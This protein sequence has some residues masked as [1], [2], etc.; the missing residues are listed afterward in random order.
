MGERA[1]WWNP[2]ARGVIFGLSRS[3]NRGHII[4]AVVEGVFFNLKVI[5]DVFRELGYKAE[6]LRIIGGGTENPLWRQIACNIYGVPLL[7]SKYPK[8]ATSLGAAIAA[9][10][11]VGALRGFEESNRLIHLEDRLEPNSELVLKYR[12]MYKLFVKLYLT[13]EPIFRE[14]AEFNF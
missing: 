2:H 1:P 13:L 7:S 4:R 11:A 14:L 10:V 9:M 12:K 5:L 6:E 8:E 3:H